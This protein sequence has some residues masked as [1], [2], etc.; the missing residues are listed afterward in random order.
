MDTRIG[1]SL[2]QYYSSLDNCN[3]RVIVANVWYALAFSLQ[4]L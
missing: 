1:R 2:S 3:K 4:Y